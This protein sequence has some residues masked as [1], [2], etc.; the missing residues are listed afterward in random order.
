[1]VRIACF[2]SFRMSGENLR[3]QILITVCLDVCMVAAGLLQAQGQAK[4]ELRNL[5]RRT[6]GLPELLPGEESEDDEILCKNDFEEYQQM[7]MP[8]AGEALKVLQ[9][10]P[11]KATEEAIAMVAF[12]GVSEATIAL[13][14]LA[15]D[16]PLLD[17]LHE[18]ITWGRQVAGLIII[19][20]RIQ[21]CMLPLC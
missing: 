8:P 2:H 10:K 17:A 4:H 1:M 11:S 5:R 13:G 6:R 7:L 18:V 14:D 15:A 16:L 3:K 19:T 21:L 20:S 9:G 12:R